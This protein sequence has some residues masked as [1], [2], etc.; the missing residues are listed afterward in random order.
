MGKL[1]PVERP[2][3]GTTGLTGECAYLWACFLLNEAD[4][5]DDYLAYDTWKATVESLKPMKGKPVPAAVHY[6]KL[7]EALKLYG[8]C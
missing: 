6:S 2:Y 7:E 5:N 3:G 1:P 4:M 8:V